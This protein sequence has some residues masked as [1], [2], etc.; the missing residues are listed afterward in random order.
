MLTGLTVVTL[1][2]NFLMTSPVACIEDKLFTWTASV[3]EFFKETP[4]AKHAYMIICGLLM[5]VMV[6]TQFY[7]FA[8]HGT[9]WRF[10]LAILMFYIFRGILQVFNPTFNFSATFPYPFP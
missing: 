7:R 6:L 9:T 5:D 3:N 4:A 2:Q 1:N 10:P 8:I